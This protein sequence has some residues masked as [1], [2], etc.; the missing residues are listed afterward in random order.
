[1]SFSFTGFTIGVVSDDYEHWAYLLFAMA[2]FDTS[3]FEVA[4]C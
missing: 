1:M 2:L 4:Q 3:V